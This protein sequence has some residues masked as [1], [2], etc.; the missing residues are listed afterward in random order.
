VDERRRRWSEEKVEG[1]EEIPSSVFETTTTRRET[2]HDL[3]DLQEYGEWVCIEELG[4]V[5]PLPFFLCYESSADFS[6]P[7]TDMDLCCVL[8]KDAPVRA[9]SELVELLGRLIEQG[10]SS[11]SSPFPSCHPLPFLPSVLTQS[12]H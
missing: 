8:A 4:C 10:S 5:F 12:R 2:D 9:A 7:V 6:F 11:F 1:G 3:T